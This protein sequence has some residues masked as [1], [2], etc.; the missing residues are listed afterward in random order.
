MRLARVVGWLSSSVG[1]AAFVSLVVAVLG[2]QTAQAQVVQQTNVQAPQDDGPAIFDSAYQGLL[3]GAAAGAG[4]GYIAARHDGWRKSDWRKVGLGIGIGALAGA[5]LG[6][7]LGF[8]DKAGAPG[9]RFVARDLAAGAGFGALMGAISGGIS[10]AINKEAEHVLFGASIGVISG[11]GLGIIT[12]IIEGQAK[13]RRLAAATT[14]TS[15]RVQPTLS[16][17]KDAHGSS[18]LVP[19][20][21]GSF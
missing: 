3:A 1:R 13:K 17:M 8:A 19:G 20:L 5:G 7:S 16:W 18:A 9:G 6:L 2:A 10:A 12:G 21:S 14:T 15:M 4:G 11:A